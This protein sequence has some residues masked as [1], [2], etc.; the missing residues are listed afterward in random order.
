MPQCKKADH[1]KIGIIDAG[2]IA[3]IVTPTP[4]QLKEAECYKS[5]RNVVGL[6]PYTLRKESE[7]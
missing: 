2:G 4:V 5:S 7:K 3:E 6:S 1:M